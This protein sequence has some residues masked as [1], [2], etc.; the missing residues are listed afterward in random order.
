LAFGKNFGEKF[1]AGVQVNYHYIYIFNEYENRNALTAEGGIQY[2][3]SKTLR[4]GIH[5]FNPSRSRLAPMNLDTLI[6]TM[7]AGISYSP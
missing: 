1:S 7:R 2:K 4:I 3:P 5:V 6:T